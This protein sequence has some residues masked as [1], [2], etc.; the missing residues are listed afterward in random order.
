MIDDATLA[1]RL[2]TQLFHCAG[3]DGDELSRDRERALNYYM[4]RPRGDEILGR[5]QVVS[6]DVSAMVEATV[7]SMMEAFTSDRICDFDPLDSDDEDQAQ[8]ESDAVQYY[9]MGRENGFLQLTMAIKEA[10]LLRNGVIKIEAVDKTERKTRRLGNVEPE[11]LAVLI[12][13]DDVVAHTYDED[14]GEL[15]VTIKQTT[16]E[17]MMTS[18]SLENFIYLES[19]HMPTLNGIPLCA[20]RHQDTRAELI[21]LGYDNA[22]VSRLTKS[23]PGKRVESKARD[24]KATTDTAT[25]IDASQDLIEWWEIYIRMAA[26]DGADELRRIA[27][28]FTDTVILE[29]IPVSRVRLASGTCI[30][31][32]HR[33]TGISL[34]DKLKQTQ[35]IRT[36]L[37]RALLDNVTATN[38]SRLAGIDGVVNVDDVSDGRI[39][40]MVRVKNQVQDIRQAIMPIVTQD[41]SANILMNLES[42]ARERAEMG[43]AALDMQ[44][45]NIQVGEGMGSQ[46]LDRAYSV[47]EQLSAAM[48]KTIACTLIRDVFLLAHATLREFFDDPLPIKRNGKWMHVK[49]SDWP[50][51]R[52]VTVKPGMSAGERSRRA[53]ALG[54]VIDAQ[55]MLA[56][57]GMDEVLVDLGGFNR[58]MLDWARLMEVQHP[59][60]YFLD[61]E[62]D[63][64]Q[65]AL[66]QKD[67]ARQAESMQRKTLMQQAFGLEQLR[68]ALGKYDGDAN[69]VLEYYKAVLDSEVEEAKIV[70]SATTD[71]VKQQREGVKNANGK[72]PSR[73]APVADKQTA[74]AGT[75][76]N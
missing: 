31:N 40:N 61:P 54:Q 3:F 2:K 38:K 46:G 32:A 70:G 53:S 11:A 42:T 24:P 44:Q 30:L 17:F 6:G 58:A 10:L 64:S 67:A 26:D 63:K 56:D 47:A 8:L 37:R 51:R 45:A 62:S 71:L 49:P 57:K 13:G 19:W 22:K 15:S 35:D 75:G 76:E 48:M 16:R 36:G 9:V 28:H 66:K 74:A 60:Q 39:N 23:I 7:A 52:S 72:V 5:A 29:N 73:S 14:S 69:R 21:A 12:S 59:E 1:A 20:L 50:E 27:L 25:A 68:V 41:T 55:M 43:G 4:Q 34:Y 65:A 18:E 33:F